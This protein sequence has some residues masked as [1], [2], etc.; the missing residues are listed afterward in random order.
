[1]K[2]AAGILLLVAAMA[3]AVRP[4]FEPIQPDV[5]TASGTFVNAFA[6][7]DGDGDPDLFVG[8]NGAPN[9]LYRNDRGRFVDVAGEAGV[10]DARA[11]RAAAWAD[12]DGDG[13]PD[14]LVGFAGPGAVLRLYRNTRGRFTD[15]TS[16]SGLTLDAGAVRQPAFI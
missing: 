8:F 11:T 13:D 9:R 7:Y 2:L 16:A 5:L 6:D 10:A 15:I 12:V 14:L 1:M 3:A 4:A